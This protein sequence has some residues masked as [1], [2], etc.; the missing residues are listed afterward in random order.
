MKTVVLACLISHSVASAP[1]PSLCDLALDRCVA[2]NRAQEKQISDLQ[3]QNKDLESRL[4]KA[5]T[6]LLIPWYV[7]AAMGAVLGGFI[8]DKLHK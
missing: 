6:P 7:Y 5:E 4:A 1:A 8:V 3:G 2:Y